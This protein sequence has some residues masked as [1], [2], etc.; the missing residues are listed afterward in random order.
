MIL[1]DHWY[2]NAIIYTL[3]VEKYQDGDGDGIGDFSGLVRRL[4]YLSGLG[5]T[6][7]WLLP[8]YPSPMRDNGYDVNDYYGVAPPVT[9][10]WA[11]SWSSLARRASAA[12]GCWSTWS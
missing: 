6:C 10:R 3:D 2:K 5:A 12:S 11:R 1:S 4:D 8:F 9:A 7:L